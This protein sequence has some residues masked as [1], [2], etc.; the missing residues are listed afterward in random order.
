M[1]Y[2]LRSFFLTH[3]SVNITITLTVSKRETQADVTSPR[4]SIQT[5]WSV[6]LCAFAVGP[7]SSAET[8]RSQSPTAPWP[9]AHPGQGWTL[10]GQDGELEGESG[11]GAWQ[12]PGATNWCPPLLWIRRG[13]GLV[14]K[15]QRSPAWVESESALHPP[16]CTH[17][18]QEV[19]DG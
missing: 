15:V 8:V 16:G 14:S 17:L 10:A 12:N 5:T 18:S 7:P 19:S 6:A 4:G 2:E 13:I 11:V 9:P 3:F 1:V